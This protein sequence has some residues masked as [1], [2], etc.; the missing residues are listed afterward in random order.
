MDINGLAA[1]VTGGGSGLGAEV[2][3]AFAKAGA[4]VAVFDGSTVTGGEPY[5][6]TVTAW[7]ERS[8]PY[9]SLS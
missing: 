3:R 8:V 4:K 9:D 6:L 7:L 2:A 1:V 5:V